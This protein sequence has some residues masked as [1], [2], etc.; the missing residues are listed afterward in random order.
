LLLATY[1]INLKKGDHLE[2]LQVLERIALKRV[3]KNCVEVALVL[4][5]NKLRIALC[6]LEELMNA[7]VN[8]N[9]YLHME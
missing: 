7:S 2:A 3:L 1:S 6:S 4:S 8:A 5:C 9:E